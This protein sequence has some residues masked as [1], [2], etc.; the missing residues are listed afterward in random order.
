MN[1]LPL[2]T[3]PPSFLGILEQKGYLILQGICITVLYN[4][5]AF[6]NFYDLAAW[7]TLGGVPQS[8][9]SSIFQYRNDC[10]D[11]HLKAI[12]ALIKYIK[13]HRMERRVTLS[14]RLSSNS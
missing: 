12:G 11:S 7:V 2:C 13:I 5:T 3:I 4:E 8:V 10:H 6:R 1:S 14:A 9:D